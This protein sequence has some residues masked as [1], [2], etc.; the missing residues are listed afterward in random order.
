MMSDAAA[1]GA[2]VPLAMSNAACSS[3]ARPELMVRSN[4]S[5]ANELTIAEAR[6]RRSFLHCRDISSADAM[7]AALWRCARLLAS[8]WSIFGDDA[9]SMPAH[10]IYQPDEQRRIDGSR[11]RRS[12]G[13]NGVSS[14]FMY[15]ERITDAEGSAIGPSKY[16]TTTRR[17]IESKGTGYHHALPARRKHV[18]CTTAGGAHAE[19]RCDKAEADQRYRHQQR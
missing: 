12:C 15:Y 6:R 2:T 9:L 13:V 7:S 8:V 4:C 17:S 19:H 1:A 5:T 14:S 3:H 11:R 10:W 18:A 16:S